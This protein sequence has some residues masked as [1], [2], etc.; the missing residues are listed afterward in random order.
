ME[1]GMYAS[2]RPCIIRLMAALH[3]AAAGAP[4]GR[5]PDP[6]RAHPS[7]LCAAVDGSRPIRRLDRP[8]G[9]RLLAPCPGQRAELGQCDH[10]RRR[11]WPGSLP[12]RALGLRGG[13]ACV[14]AGR[15][16]AGD[17]FMTDA[18]AAWAASHALE[19]F[20]ALPLLAGAA[21]FWGMRAYVGR[22]RRA[23]QAIYVSPAPGRHRRVRWRFG[24]CPE[25][26]HGY[27]AAVAAV[28]VHLSGR[29]QLPDGAERADDALSALDRLVAAG[30]VLRDCHRHGR[31]DQLVAQAHL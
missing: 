13:H 11:G 28:L 24:R 12:R 25:H 8:G 10:A 6:G 30:G 29:P 21:A 18:W 20:I 16:D 4:G 7:A 19:L 22:P 15:Q 14:R 2:N 26:D 17:A 1:P 3:R 23:R 5:R 9:H 27:L 31:R